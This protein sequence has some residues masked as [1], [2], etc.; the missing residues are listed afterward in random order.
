MTPDLD[1]LD[2]GE[3]VKVG[4]GVKVIG[5]GRGG[6][7][8]RGH[9]RRRGQGCWSRLGSG[10]G[11]GQGGQMRGSWLG[12]HGVGVRGAVGFSGGGKV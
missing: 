5:Q 10:E 8:V 2:L 6:V 4:G 3:G 1:P 12:G 7:K 9:R 11:Q